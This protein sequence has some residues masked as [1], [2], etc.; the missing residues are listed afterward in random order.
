[1]TWPCT[2]FFQEGIN[3]TLQA[4][5]PWID[6]NMCLSQYITLAIHLDNLLH[7]QHTL[8]NTAATPELLELGKIRMSTEK[9]KK[10][11][12]GGPEYFSF[13]SS[14]TWPYRISVIPVIPLIGF[15]FDKQVDPWP[16]GGRTRVAYR[17]LCHTIENH[18]YQQPTHRKCPVHTTLFG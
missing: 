16:T 7:S 10:P 11:G 13:Q 4:E 15:Q 14:V 17:P 1:M 9:H 8:S 6:K 5:M 12:Q 18:S 2:Y 3:P